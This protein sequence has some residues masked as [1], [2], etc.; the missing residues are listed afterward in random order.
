MGWE[1]GIGS[2]RNPIGGRIRVGVE[3]RVW[4]WELEDLGK[5]CGDMRRE[6]WVFIGDFRGIEML[7]NIL[8]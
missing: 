7:R 2:V 6:K 1:R 4:L 8:A 3:W 5:N